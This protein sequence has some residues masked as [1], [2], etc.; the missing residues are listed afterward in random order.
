METAPLPTH[1]ESKSPLAH[2]RP[3]PHVVW[4]TQSDAAV[5]LD[6]DRGLYLTLNSVAARTWELLAGGEPLTAILECLED[7][8]E[9][10]R[11]QLEDDVAALL[12]HLVELGLIEESSS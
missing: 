8:Y 3:L 5:L 1:F 12:K 9:I 6:A 10:G 11:Q 7:E 4:I 2:F